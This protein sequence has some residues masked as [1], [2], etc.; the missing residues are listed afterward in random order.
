MRPPSE[1]TDHL[2]SAS[3]LLSML[4]SKVNK[5]FFSNYG[6]CSHLG[7]IQK[8]VNH[9]LGHICFT[10]LPNM[11]SDMRHYL[12]GDIFVRYTFVLCVN[13]RA[14]T[15]KLRDVTVTF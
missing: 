4:Y 10:V 11:N 8:N 7:S 13:G 3:L 14:K 2:M 9:T 12:S 15:C 1:D 6:S 5:F